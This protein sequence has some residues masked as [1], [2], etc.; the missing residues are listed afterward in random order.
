MLTDSIKNAHS[1][2]I[3]TSL[4]KADGIDFESWENN[5]TESKFVGQSLLKDRVQFFFGIDGLSKL[6]FGPYIRNVDHET[7]TFLYNPLQ[8]HAF[9]LEIFPASKLVTLFIPLERLHKLFSAEDLPILRNELIQQKF[10]QDKPITQ[11]LLFTLTPLFKNQVSKSLEQTYYYGKLLE[12]ISLYFSDK[13]SESALSCPFLN[14]VNTLKKIKQAKEILLHNLNHPPTI[15]DLARQVNIVEYQLKSGFKE[16]YGN[17][18]ASYVLVKK[19]EKA[20]KLFDNQ[21]LQVNEVAYDL[22]YANPSH[23]IA[24]FKKQFGVTPKKYVM[25]K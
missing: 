3:Q 25:K 20:R 24:A 21:N 6:H 11:S 8:E 19:M 14:D 17:T 1:N 13:E 12:V 16:L 10:Y 9:Q 15:A 7:A 22:G 18:I 2:Q 5:E 4:Y 23:F